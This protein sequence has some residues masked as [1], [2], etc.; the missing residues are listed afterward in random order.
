MKPS[1]LTKRID[2]LKE[3][4]EPVPSEGIRFD[5]NSFTEP[6]QLVLLKNFELHDKYK[7]RWTREIIL[8]NKDIILKGNHI[9]MTRACELFQTAMLGAMM[10]DDLEAWFFKFHFND[11]LSHW[12]E[13]LKNLEKWSKKDREDFLRDVQ[14]EP[15]NENRVKVSV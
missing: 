13:C 7:S 9:V 3:K 10:V 11:F 6:E 4:L 8:E 1:Q 15:K 12:V 14:L 5:F 2:E